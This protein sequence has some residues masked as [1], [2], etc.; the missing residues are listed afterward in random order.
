MANEPSGVDNK[1]DKGLVFGKKESY[2]DIVLK[3][4]ASG[5]ENEP[6]RLKEE[7]KI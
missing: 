7:K 4:M 3:L 2:D 6:L 1:L 5:E